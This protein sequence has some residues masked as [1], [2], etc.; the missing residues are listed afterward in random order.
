MSEL[1]RRTVTAEMVGNL[2]KSALDGDLCE[3]VLDCVVTNLKGTPVIIFGVDTVNHANNFLL[4]RGLC[5]EAVVLHINN[6]N[7]GNP[8]LDAQWRQPVGSVYQDYDLITEH[9]MRAWSR[10]KEWYGMLGTNRHATGIVLDRRESKQLVLELHYPTAHESR[11]RRPATE[12]FEGLA[13]HLVLGEQ[14]MRLQREFP[15]EGHMATSLL[16]LS[17]LPILIIDTDDRVHNMNCRAQIMAN[18]MD[19]FFISAERQFHAMDMASETAFK[20]ALHAL[21]TGSRKVS[22]IITLWNS[23]RSRRVFVALAKLGGATPNRAF[24]IQRFESGQDQ[25]ALIVQDVDEQLDLAPDTLWKAFRLSNAECDL[26]LKLLRGD[27]IG[28]IAYENHISKQTLR[29]QLSSIMKKTSTSRQSQLVSLL[30]KLA[31]APLS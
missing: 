3:A 10:H 12:L 5:T 11:Y 4:H 21:T 23:D 13:P 29:N 18:Q 14:I 26:A 15:I 28:D 24:P 22:D 27:T 30:T 6:L 20:S 16:E 2:Y 1:I 9:E 17:G 7:V 19:T 25:I 8:W 31:F